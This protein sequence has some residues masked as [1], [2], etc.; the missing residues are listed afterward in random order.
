MSVLVAI[1][2][3]FAGCKSYALT[4]G[5]Y[6]AELL[7]AYLLHWCVRVTGSSAAGR[8]ASPAGACAARSYPVFPGG[9]SAALAVGAA[10]CRCLPQSAQLYHARTQSMHFRIVV[11]ACHQSISASNVSIL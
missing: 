4:T 2:P 8:T 11:Y 1:E 10:W 3:R 9:F 7:L 5:V 6:T